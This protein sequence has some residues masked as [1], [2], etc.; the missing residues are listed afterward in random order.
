MEEQKE[1]AGELGV[2]VDRLSAEG[3][4]PYIQSRSTDRSLNGLGNV[5]ELAHYICVSRGGLGSEKIGIETDIKYPFMEEVDEGQ[6]E[7]E[8]E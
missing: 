1:V 2:S 5:G 8:T 7:S 6:P 3:F 4:I